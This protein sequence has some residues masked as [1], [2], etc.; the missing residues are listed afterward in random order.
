MSYRHCV[1]VWE[2][3]DVSYFPHTGSNCF[4]TERPPSQTHPSSVQN[5]TWLGVDGAFNEITYG[6]AESGNRRYFNRN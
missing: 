3:V 1:T 4:L 2:V 6:I 5:V